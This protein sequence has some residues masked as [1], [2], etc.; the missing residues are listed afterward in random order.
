MEGP[1][2]RA[3]LEEHHAVCFGWAVHCCDGDRNEAEDVLQI[4]YLEVLEERA[5]F[6]GRSQVRTWL[7][8]IIRNIAA[9]RRR[10]RRALLLRRADDAPV[11]HPTADPTTDVLAQ[12]QEAA[13]RDALEHLPRRQREVIVLTFY[14][15]MTVEAASEVL[16]ISIGSARTHYHRGKQKLRSLLQHENRS[17]A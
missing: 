7:F 17:D 12:E 3:A 11:G 15:G 2:I 1:D 16:R 13:L 5:Q 8:G 10:L 14:E 9:S 4:A 6:S